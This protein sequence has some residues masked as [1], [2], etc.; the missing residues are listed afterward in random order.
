MFI[1]LAFSSFTMATQGQW[2][3]G[4]TWNARAAGI[5]HWPKPT[6][7]STAELPTWHSHLKLVAAVAC[8]GE[9]RT[10]L[11]RWY[12]AWSRSHGFM[13]CFDHTTE[14]RWLLWLWTGAGSSFFFTPISN[15]KKTPELNPKILHQQSRTLSISDLN[16]YTS[17]CHFSI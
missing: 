7:H 1:Q 4:S 2:L 10:G 16:S 5:Q 17:S 12:N 15:G 8:P 9:R 14:V 13:D 6:L 11:P 3:G